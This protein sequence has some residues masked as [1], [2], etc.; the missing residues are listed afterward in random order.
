[1]SVFASATGIWWLHALAFGVS[2]TVLMAA[3]VLSWGLVIDAQQNRS[4][5]TAFGRPAARVMVCTGG[6]AAIL[7]AAFCVLA[8]VT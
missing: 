7:W 3:G 6:A 5:I 8:A 2:G 4:F 1:M